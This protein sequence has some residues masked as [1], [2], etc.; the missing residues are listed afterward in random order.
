M[1][2]TLLV[3]EK[4]QVYMVIFHTLIYSAI[5]TLMYIEFSTNQISFLVLFL[6]EDTGEVTS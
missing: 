1:S 3:W 6:Y 5:Y 4:D 2:R